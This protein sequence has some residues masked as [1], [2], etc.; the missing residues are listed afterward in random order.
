MD[1]GV[2]AVPKACSLQR[3]LAPAIAAAEEDTEETLMQLWKDHDICAGIRDCA[4]VVSPRSAR[5]A[6]ERRHSG[7][8]SVT[9]KNLPRMRRLQKPLQLW[10]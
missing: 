5:V 4:G 10:W 7:G 8:S 3:T 2:I 9:S 1:Q 6:S